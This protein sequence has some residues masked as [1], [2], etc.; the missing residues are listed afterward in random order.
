MHLAYIRRFRMQLDFAETW[1]PEP[2]LPAGFFWVPWCD[3]LIDRHAAVKYASFQSEMDARVFPCLGDSTGCRHLMSEIA[4]HRCFLPHATWL[5]GYRDVQSQ[6]FFDCATIQGMKKRWR[7]GSIQNVGVTPQFRGMGLGRAL[8]LK[9]LHG[10]R[11]SKMRRVTLEVTAE[12][13]PAINLYSSLGF[14]TLR[15]M[16][17]AVET[18]MDA[19]A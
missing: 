3:S 9:S 4:D 8:L 18:R 1:I 17:H 10:F 15:T 6:T 7:T 19:M 12:N 16:F 13:Q 14:R 11:A 2:K 5:I